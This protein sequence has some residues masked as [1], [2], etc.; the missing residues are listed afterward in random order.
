MKALFAYGDIVEFV[1]EE[2]ISR[3]GMYLRSVD[4]DFH[5]VKICGKNW[6]VWEADM[7][8]RIPGTDGTFGEILRDFYNR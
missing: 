8:G 7:V 2:G 5:C 1:D 4:D 3:G 6:I